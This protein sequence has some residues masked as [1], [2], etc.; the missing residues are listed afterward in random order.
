[1]GAGK[2]AVARVSEG[3][4]V[5]TDEGAPAGGVTAARASAG[6]KVLPI[7]E[8]LVLLVALVLPLVLQ[9]YL[10]VF[11]TRVAIL[12][13]FA[14]SFDLVWGYAGIM[15]FGQALFFG[16]AGYGVA[17]LARDLN[18]TSIFLI[19]PAGTL[20]GLTASLLLGGFLLL[21]RY[22]S[23]VIFVS[24]GTLTGS[25]A[26]DRLARGWYYLGGQNGIPS[27]PAM[28][29]GSYD[30]E[31]GVAFYYLALGIL[32]VVYLL[33]RFLVRSQFG[34]ALAGLRE[35]EQRIAFFGYKAQHLKAII[36]AIG[37]TIAGLAGSLYAFHEGFVWPNM[38]GV[39]FSTQVVLY[40]LFGGSGT[41]I[42]AVIGTVM[43][44]GVSFWLSD[45]YRDIWP[46][47]LGVLLLLVIM[48]RPLGLISFVLGERERVGSFGKV[49]RERSNA[50]P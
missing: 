7:V 18:V 32:V 41:L 21:G 35:N 25:Y 10:T 9:D 15:S 40:V 44:E 33:C 24:L 43:I 38:L 16:A 19:L 48:F 46:I 17:L 34:L 23:S 4:D 8:V 31:E 36:F 45:N 14:L 39:V 30:L 50:A 42:G 22:P 49:P 13:L 2:Q 29:I 37:G 12:A 27:I 3:P 47:I 1:M 6:W 20:I 28:S 26:A 11:A 5:V